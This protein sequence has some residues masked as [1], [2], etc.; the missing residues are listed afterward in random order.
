MSRRHGPQP[1]QNVD[2]VG[3]VKRTDKDGF[4]GMQLASSY[5]NTARHFGRSR[6]RNGWNPS[7][8]NKTAAPLK[9]MAPK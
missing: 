8:P 3:W 6:W 2:K 1:E 4:V 5:G 7:S 9:H